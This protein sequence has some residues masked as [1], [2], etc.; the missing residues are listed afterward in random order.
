[1]KQSRKHL[2]SKELSLKGMA[3]MYT[4]LTK[5]VILI[6]LLWLSASSV[7]HA[8]STNNTVDLGLAAPP[9]IGNIVT[10][11]VVLILIIGLIVILIRFLAHKNNS[12]FSSRSIRHLGGVGL[13]QNKSV[14][15]VKIGNTLY[16]VGVGEDVRLLEKIDQQ[17]E[18]DAIFKSL[19]STPTLSGKGII[20]Y[21]SKSL[22][23]R[24]Q[25]SLPFDVND[26]SA[27]SSF[28]EIFYNKMQQVSDQR[29]QFKKVL[30][31]DTKSDGNRS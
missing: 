19:N 26:P 5:V 9:N 12:W 18:I 30:E 21:L 25:K 29:Q 20:A 4:R 27:A 1:M 6:M 24:R 22:N 15:M 7:V 14:Q 31:D 13:G 28:Q 2:G 17:D 11:I 10:V 8:D 16:V 3:L 23:F